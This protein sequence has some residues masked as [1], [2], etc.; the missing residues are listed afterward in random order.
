MHEGAARL[1]RDLGL[2]PHPE[3]GYF[4]EAYRSGSRV[5]AGAR[6]RSAVTSIYYLLAGDDFSAFHRLP[7]DEL[8]HH[9]EGADVA[10]ECIDADGTHRRVVIGAG[11]ARQAAIQPG[12]WF[13][14]HLAEG[15]AYALVGC[16]VAPGFEYD[17]F[18]IAS[19]TALRGA[20]PRHAA[21]IE[22]LTRAE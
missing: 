5:V 11:G 2:R 6:A 12:V 14:A 17:D 9:Y 1:I 18:E 8:W 19:R 13:A 20:Y 10:I 21:L 22:R 15:G 4:S 16:D 7:S 3:G